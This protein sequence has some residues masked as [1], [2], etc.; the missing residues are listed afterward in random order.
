MGRLTNARN[1]ALI[2]TILSFLLALFLLAVFAVSSAVA[3]ETQSKYEEAS[4]IELTLNDW[5][6]ADL[7]DSEEFPPWRFTAEKAGKYIIEAKPANEDFDGE[8]LLEVSEDEEDS[9]GC[10]PSASLGAEMGDALICELRA[11]QS[12]T[13]YVENFSD[14]EDA[15]ASDACLLRAREASEDEVAQ[16]SDIAS[17]VMN[18]ECLS[19]LYVSNGTIWKEPEFEAYN[20]F[21]D[22]YL[23]IGVDY[24]IEGYYWYSDDQASEESEPLDFWE[25]QELIE[26]E[27][28]SDAIVCVAKLKGIGLYSGD[29][30]YDDLLCRVK[31]KTSLED[32]RVSIGLEQSAFTYTGSAQK[33][34]VVV[35]FGDRLLSKGSDYTTTYENNVNAGHAVVSVK[36]RGEYSGEA[37]AYFTIEPR[38][39]NS[40]NT[41][42]EVSGPAAGG[43]FKATGKAI[44]PNPTVRLG[45]KV[46][47][48]GKDYTVEASNNVCPGT[49]KCKIKGK[50]N[51]KGSLSCEFWIYG[52]QG[53]RHVI[54]GITYKITKDTVPYVNR[55]GISWPCG[56]VQVVGASN[57]VK[58]RAT[59]NLPGLVKIG[60]QF[61]AVSSIK[62]SVFKGCKKIKKITISSNTV[63][64]GDGAFKNCTSLKTVKMGGGSMR[65]GK[66]AFAGCVKLSNL[67]LAGVCSVI[68]DRAFYGCGALK[69][70]TI[71]TEVRSIGKSAF[72]K[73]SK[74]KTVKIKSR[75]LTKIGSRA[76]FKCKQLKTVV[77]RGSKLKSVGKQAF[78]G[79]SKGLTVRAPE[80]KNSKY[81]K[82]LAKSAPGTFRVRPLTSEDYH[83]F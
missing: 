22:E 47:V 56:E 31:P 1:Q 75:K 79:A 70:V 80:S 4:C 14:Q 15:D 36:G 58:K 74:L 64:I 73:C 43:W 9:E 17:A 50:G 65:I 24:S 8:M 13:G 66:D 10:P 26:N 25:V 69:S 54:D 34:A 35:T 19:G 30:W 68:G 40:A 83:N 71:P 81:R 76:F 37:K 62:S 82:L 32:K 28:N 63:S 33:P 44:D 45:D 18:F 48:A 5:V 21:A 23:E 53:S 38:T 78:Q 11:G 59:L 20:L 72:E 51:Y 3:A 55:T 52:Q 29:L 49:A 6:H 12:I 42:L 57:A 16:L 61:Y 41:S 67:K 77:I 46:L 27:P 2:Q 60:P 39:I 7:L